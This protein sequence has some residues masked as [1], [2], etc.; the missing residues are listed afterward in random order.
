MQTVMLQ[1]KHVDLSKRL[2]PA[3][4]KRIKQNLDAVLTELMQADVTGK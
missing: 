3:R 1:K 2:S 4:K